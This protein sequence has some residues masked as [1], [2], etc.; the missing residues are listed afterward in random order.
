MPAVQK[1]RPQQIPNSPVNQW[2]CE[3]GWE[4]DKSGLMNGA[5]GSIRA[6]Y[7]RPDGS[8]KQHKL[9]EKNNPGFL[10]WSKKGL[11]AWKQAFKPSEQ[12][13]VMTANGIIFFKNITFAPIDLVRTGIDQSLA[14]GVDRYGFFRADY[15]KPI[16]GAILQYFHFLLLCFSSPQHLI[17]LVTSYRFRLLIL[18][19]TRLLTV[20]CYRS[21]I[22]VLHIFE[23]GL[24]ICNLIRKCWISALIIVQG[25]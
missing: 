12:E 16:F 1:N 17:H 2:C 11:T 10:F 21:D 20:T 7:I 3:A 22:V 15:W 24:F 23:I 9:R 19:Q 13:T 6:G 4:S 18:G 5:G 14:S 8:I 25:S